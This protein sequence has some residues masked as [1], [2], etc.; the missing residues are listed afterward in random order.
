MNRHDDVR[1]CFE[2]VAPW[3]LVTEVCIRVATVI[4]FNPDFQAFSPFFRWWSCD[5]LTPQAAS[6]RVR[7]RENISLRGHRNV[8]SPGLF[9]LLLR[10][11]DSSSWR[12]RVFTSILSACRAFPFTRSHD[13]FWCLL[14][15][16]GAGTGAAVSLEYGSSGAVAGTVDT[17]DCSGRKSYEAGATL[18]T[19]PDQD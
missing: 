9:W 17:G 11:P 1:T 5:L 19:V 2:S 16:D 4:R 12:L 13:I 6:I 15:N 10:R 18:V 14:R 7:L 3:S 8:Q